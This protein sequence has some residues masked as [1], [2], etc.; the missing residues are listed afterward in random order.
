MGRTIVDSIAVRIANEGN[1]AK[2]TIEERLT[3]LETKITEKDKAAIAEKKQLA[4]DI[5]E[6]KG[7]IKTLIGLHTTTEGKKSNGKYHQN[8]N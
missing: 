5:A 1:K 7:A 3:G 8:N 2:S 4:Q 6:I